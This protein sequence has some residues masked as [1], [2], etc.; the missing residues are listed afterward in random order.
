MTV[1]LEVRQRYAL[2][3][4]TIECEDFC[5]IDPVLFEYDLVAALAYHNHALEVHISVCALTLDF[6]DGGVVI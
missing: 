4:D 5:S 6:H 3:S 1:S 2:R